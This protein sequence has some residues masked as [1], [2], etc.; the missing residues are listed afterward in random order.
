[1]AKVDLKSIENISYE[2]AFA[3]LEA[4]VAALES[5]EQSLDDSLGL[6]ERGQLLTRYCA[7]LLDRAELKV[8]TLSGEMIGTLPEGE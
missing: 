5:G 1:M 2:V 8:R 3:E 7:D 6:F 4:V